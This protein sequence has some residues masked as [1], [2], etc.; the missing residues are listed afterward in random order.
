MTERQQLFCDY[1]ARYSNGKRAAIAAGYREKSA[2]VCAS[3]LLKLPEIQAT[4]DKKRQYVVHAPIAGESEILE[5]LT[6]I[7]RGEVTDVTARDRM[8]AAELLGRS[9]AL[10]TD[11]KRA[12]QAETV[13][14]YNEENIAD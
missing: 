8:K 6:K 14:F 11:S 2:A 3:R 4:I 10:F 1:Y 9:A 5:Y 13:C 7:M 12:E